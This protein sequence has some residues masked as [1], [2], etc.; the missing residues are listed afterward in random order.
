MLDV[1]VVSSGPGLANVIQNAALRPRLNQLVWQVGWLVT[2]H[3]KTYAPFRYGHLKAS[4]HPEQIGELE[5]RVV[6][7]LYYGIYQEYGT[8][9]HKAHPFMRP[10][11]LAVKQQMGG[12]VRTVA[13]DAFG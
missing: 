6:T 12:L 4:I 7:T 1:S 8:R 13:R 11:A 5:V 3:A 10:A 9:R 2:E